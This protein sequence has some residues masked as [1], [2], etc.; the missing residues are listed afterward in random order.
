MQTV[1]GYLG[2]MKWTQVSPNRAASRRWVNV[3]LL[4]TVFFLPLH[5]H[6]ATAS[7][8][9]ISQECSC[10]HGSRTQLGQIT[11]PLASVPL[12]GH[13]VISAFQQAAVISRSVSS[14]LSR[15]PPAV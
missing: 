11:P 1:P 4:V 13:V 14:H 15:A 12:V 8:A 10:I 5:F 9:Q 7:T 2:V 3:F 6:I